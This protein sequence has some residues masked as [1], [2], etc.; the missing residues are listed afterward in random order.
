MK[1]PQP[2]FGEVLR[3]YRAELAV[4]NIELAAMLETVPQTIDNWIH[5][6]SKPAKF[7]QQAIIAHLQG[8][9]DRRGPV[10]VILPK[11]KFKKR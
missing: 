4:G 9:I 3:G 10:E 6:K 11:T 2:S 1:T 5:G 8:I 7:V